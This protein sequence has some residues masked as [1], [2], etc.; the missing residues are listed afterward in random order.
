M[1][2]S[3]NIDHGFAFNEQVIA[4]LMRSDDNPDE[5]VIVLVSGNQFLI[6]KPLSLVVERAS[7][8]RKQQRAELTEEIT[9]FMKQH[10]HASLGPS[11]IENLAEALAKQLTKE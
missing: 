7:E 5:T 3:V 11:S 8:T 4:C 2:L 6:K 10:L 9:D 1:K